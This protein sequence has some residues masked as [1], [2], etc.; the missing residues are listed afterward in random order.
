MAREL[1]L[2]L[3]KKESKFTLSKIQRKNIYGYKK[4]MVTAHGDVTIVNKTGLAKLNRQLRKKGKIEAKDFEKVGYKK[5]DITGHV[6][7]V[8]KK[9]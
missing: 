5:L 6:P 7:P 3:D 2:L 4:R 8:K 1:I 9:W